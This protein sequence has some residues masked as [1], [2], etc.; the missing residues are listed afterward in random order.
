TSADSVFQIAAHERVV[1]LQA[2]YGACNIARAI[3]I[4]PHNVSRVI[5]RPFDGE[6]G[7]FQ[8][9][10]AHRLDV[11]IE[12]PGETLLDA[13]KAAGISRTGIGKV[14]DLFARRGI[15][16]THTPTNAAGITAVVEWLQS[17]TSGFLF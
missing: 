17:A 2:L 10:S 6:P 11:S 3:L 5:A 16:A 12:P 9:V 7:A 14:D 15:T 8:R 1:S 13:L 4:E